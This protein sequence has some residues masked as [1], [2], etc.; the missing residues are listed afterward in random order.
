M[1]CCESGRLCVKAT[2]GAEVN[3][4][5]AFF[6][7]HADEG[8]KD[9]EH[10][11]DSDETTCR[12]STSNP[13][14]SNATEFRK[15]YKA[16]KQESDHYKSHGLEK[17]NGSPSSDT[18]GSETTVNRGADTG[19]ITNVTK[20]DRGKASLNGTDDELE[21]LDKIEKTARNASELG[22]AGVLKKC[23]HRGCKRRPI[24]GSEGSKFPVYCKLHA[25]DGM[26]EVI[27][28]KCADERCNGR[29][30]FGWEPGSVQNTASCT[31]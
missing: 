29:S 20:R 6:S 24:F 28:K 23:T 16:E 9:V 1:M 25:T 10:K 13:M 12:Q 27:K 7:R 17:C 15:P 31:R 2:F 8:M 19:D 14:L 4:N 18:K 26:V 11:L 5:P 22:M 21:E 3:N 30:T